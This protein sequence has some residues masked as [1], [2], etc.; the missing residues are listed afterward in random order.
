MLQQSVIIQKSI[1]NK[2]LLTAI[3][4]TFTMRTT[5]HL[6]DFDRD[7]EVPQCE[8][9]LINSYK[10]NGTQVASI[11]FVI[12]IFMF[13]CHSLNLEIWTPKETGDMPEIM[14]R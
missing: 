11:Y 13:F 6:D 7:S 12:Y 5:W 9:L 8:T 14:L 1:I 10:V 4:I 2:Q 3:S